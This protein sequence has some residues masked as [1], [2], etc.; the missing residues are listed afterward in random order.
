MITMAE[1][2]DKI[3]IELRKDPQLFYAY[4]ANIA[5]SFQD[6]CAK[7]GYKFPDLHAISNQAAVN[8]LNLWI[9][10]TE[11]HEKGKL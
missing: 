2:F 3:S 7:A 11:D 8:F 10:R 1:A 5:M 9:K 6:E 4:Q